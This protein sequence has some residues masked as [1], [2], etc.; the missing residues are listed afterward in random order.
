[1]NKYQ[2]GSY[3]IPYEYASGWINTTPKYNIAVGTYIEAAI[4]LPHAIGFWP[5]YWLFGSNYLQKNEDYEEI[6]GF[7]MLGH[8]PSYT[9]GTNL[10][11]GYLPGFPPQG[12]TAF[13][14]A[15]SSFTIPRDVDIK[16]YSDSPP[17]NIYYANTEL[18]FGMLYEMNTI[19]YYVNG[20][21]QETKPNPGIYNPKTLILN[22]AI[23]YFA[24]TSTTGGGLIPNLDANGKPEYFPNTMLESNFTTATMKVNWVKVW[25]VSNDNIPPA[26]KEPYVVNSYNASV[27]AWG[28]VW[29]NTTATIMC[30]LNDNYYTNSDGL[31]KIEYGLDP[32]ASYANI[33]HI[34]QS[35][36]DH[37][38]SITLNGLQSNTVYYYKVSVEGALSQ[39][40]D[41]IYSFRTSS[42]NTSNPFIFYGIGN[43]CALNSSSS[44]LNT[45][46][47]S[48]QI[49]TEV[50]NTNQIKNPMIIHTGNRYAGSTELNWQTELFN[51]TNTKVQQLMATLPVMGIKGSNEST[52]E[53]FRKYMPFRGMSD[54]ITGNPWSYSFDNGPVHYTVLHIDD[55]T[56]AINGKTR[57]WLKN[58]LD[59]AYR[60]WKV[61]IVHYPLYSLTQ[62]LVPNSTRD[63]IHQIAKDKG[64][65]LIIMGH[66]PYYAH[67]VKDGI[68]YMTLGGGGE[69]GKIDFNKI[70][71]SDEVFA[72]TVPHFA[73]F[74]VQND[75]ILV[76]VIQGANANG[77]QVGRRIE[78]F[79]IP[80]QNI[81]TNT[82]ATIPVTVSGYPILMNSVIVQN[83]KFHTINGQVSMLKIHIYKLKKEEN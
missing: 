32:N 39:L 47:I 61:I 72:S 8:K 12:T 21:L 74:E 15:K 65:Q 27:T 59:T 19:K 78:K 83:G 44:N 4:T 20:M 80:K 52:G 18:I 49:L 46:K 31:C 71:L 16:D 54:S 50:A 30:Q 62:E 17:S 75:L 23:S 13:G 68:H 66:D 64:V 25:E 58:D 14:Y 43:T 67:W 55:N 40:F 69:T 81:I 53:K 77:Y 48:R 82:V 6:D 2:G 10:V 37:L 34:P 70:Q 38:Y 29:N 63:V 73:K 45:N 56:H 22:F 33:Q 51:Q 60:E 28:P 3:S 1:M 79:A 35:S 7:E 9:M 41:T 36:S 11:S 5:A 24:D 26:T 42:Q 76:D 57:E